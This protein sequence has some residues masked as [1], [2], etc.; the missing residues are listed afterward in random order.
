[1]KGFA[2]IVAALVV[3]AA[4][5]ICGIRTGRHRAEMAAVAVLTVQSVVGAIRGRGHT[6]HTFVRPAITGVATVVLLWHGR[7][8]FRAAAILHAVSVAVQ[9][10]EPALTEIVMCLGTRSHLSAIPF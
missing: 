10:S 6:H 2:F 3:A 9:P 1:M 7:Q 4:A 8:Q 5:A